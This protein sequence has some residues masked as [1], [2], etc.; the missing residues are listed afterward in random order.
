MA[1]LRPAVD[2]RVSGAGRQEIFIAPAVNLHPEPRRVDSRPVQ[3]SELEFVR[4]HSLR[5]LN[6]K[7]DGKGVGLP[8]R[9]IISGAGMDIRPVGPTVG[10]ADH[11]KPVILISPVI[12]G[13]QREF[14]VVM[15]RFPDLPE[16]GGL[17]FHPDRQQ[18]QQD[19]R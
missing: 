6:T 17:L 5:V 10:L 1:L 3:E 16:E 13:G 19:R 4:T 12:S 18:D 14:P 7:P 9:E 11:K 15:I 8:S 2:G